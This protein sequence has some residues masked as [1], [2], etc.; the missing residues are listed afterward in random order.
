[1][2]LPADKGDIEVAAALGALSPQSLTPH[3]PE[4]LTWLQDDNWP[5]ARPVAAAL[6]RCGPELVEPMR[7]VLSGTDAVWKYWVAMFLQDVSPEVRA[8]L[9]DDI[10]RV[11]NSPTPDEE[12]EGVVPVMRDVFFMMNYV[13]PSSA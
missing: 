8:A 12:S 6:A 11:L 7:R 10:I 3:I 13:D 5:V 9:T 4:L 1:M 2:R